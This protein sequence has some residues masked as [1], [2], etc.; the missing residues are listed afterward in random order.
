MDIEWK[1]FVTALLLTP[2]IILFTTFFAYESYQLIIV[3]RR[4]RR[5]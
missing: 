1:T 2:Y 5:R 3:V 4:N